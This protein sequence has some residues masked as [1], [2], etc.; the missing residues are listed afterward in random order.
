MIM[1][2][3]LP[4]TPIEF[5][6]ALAVQR[7]HEPQ[8]DETEFFQ[9]VL[10]EIFQRYLDYAEEGHYDTVKFNGANLEVVGVTG[11]VSNVIKPSGES[12]LADFNTDADKL[13]TLLEDQ[14]GNIAM[15]Q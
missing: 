12:F 14:A 10:T 1:L 5:Q 9:T 13:L 15:Q 6:E 2:I 7:V 8:T 3:N 11:K 4:T